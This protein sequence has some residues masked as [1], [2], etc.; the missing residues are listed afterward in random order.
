MKLYFPCIL[1]MVL[2][3]CANQQPTRPN[4][5]QVPFPSDWSIKDT[6]SLRNGSYNEAAAPDSASKITI[7]TT[8]YFTRGNLDGQPV[9]AAVLTTSPPGSGTFYDIVIFQEKQ[10]GLHYLTQ[11]ALGDRV[12]INQVNITDNAL[13]IALT[14]RTLDTAMTEEPDLPQVKTFHM[15]GGKLVEPRKPVAT[16][17]NPATPLQDLDGKTFYWQSSLYGNDTQ[18]TP[19]TPASFS[20]TFNHDWS[21]TILTDCGKLGGFYGLHNSKLTIKPE[22]RKVPCQKNSQEDLFLKDLQGAIYYMLKDKNMYIDLMYDTG[23]LILSTHL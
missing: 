14:T 18:E 13:K 1:L 2:A 23:T 4:L 22:H 6:I 7:A 8:P 16:P 21:L 15:Q 11:M 19:H 10:N 5:D 12:Q 3:G 17:E 20:I 9:L